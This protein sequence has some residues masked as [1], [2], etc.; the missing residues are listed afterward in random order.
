MPFLAIDFGWH[1]SMA[2][3]VFFFFALL[4]IVMQ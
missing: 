1:Y 3:N 2:K 4:A